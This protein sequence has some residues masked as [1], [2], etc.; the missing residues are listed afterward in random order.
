MELCYFAFLLAAVAFSHITH[1]KSQDYYQPEQLH[2]SYPDDPTKMTVTWSTMS[3]TNSSVCEYGLESLNTTATGYSK[4]FTDGG[5]EKRTQ[6]IHRVTLTDLIPGETYWYHCGSIWGWSEL[7]FFKAIKSGYDWSPR[8]ALFGDMGNENAQSL[9]YLQ[10][11]T[12]KG[13]Y[14]AIIHIGDFAYDMDTN[15]ARYGDQ[16]MRQI[17]PIAGYAPYMVC[18]GNH[19]QMYNFSNYKNRFTMPHTDDNMFYS[20]DIGP[21]HF[22]AVSTEFYFF[23]E[24]GLKQIVNQYQWLE[25]DLKEA[26]KAEN[27]AQRPWIVLFGHRPMYCSNNDDD[28]CTHVESLVRVGMP[29]LHWYGMENLLNLYGVDLALW[30]HEHSYER[31]W[32]VYNEKIMNGSIDKPYTNPRATVHLT[33]GSAGCSEQHD[34]FKEASPPWTAFR[35][36]EYGYTRMKVFNTTHLYM[37]QVAVEKEGQII[38]SFWL[39]K[40]KHAP[41]PE[42]FPEETY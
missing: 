9:P 6:I 18:P 27:R 38:D 21:V 36:I 3:D 5:D 1:V 22:I 20:F 7:Y 37:E 35:S 26:N 28:D 14:D 25:R 41:F 11:E 12:Q 23:L 33:T 39:V 13:N 8:F 2:L 24:Y 40:S 30:A 31:L 4:V 32:P 10:E 16:F 15:N 29:L 42:L 34:N 19:E 17:Q